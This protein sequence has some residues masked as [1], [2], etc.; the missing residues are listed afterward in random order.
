MRGRE[1]ASRHPPIKDWKGPRRAPG[2]AHNTEQWLLLTTSF[3]PRI[4]VL[5]C[6]RSSPRNVYARE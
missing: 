4:A 1:R 2:Q 6:Y 5:H 3:L